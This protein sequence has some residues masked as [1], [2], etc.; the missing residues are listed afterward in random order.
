MW[1]QTGEKKE[2]E[3]TEVSDATAYYMPGCRSAPLCRAAFS[4]PQYE[5]FVTVLLGLLECEGKRTL[6]GIRGIVNLM[7]KWKSFLGGGGNS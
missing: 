4:K 2:P 1:Y 3:T 6:S 7:N 5:Y